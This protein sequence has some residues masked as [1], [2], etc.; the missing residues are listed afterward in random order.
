[1][2][3]E[4]VMTYIIGFLCGSIV[5]TIIIYIHEKIRD[6]KVED[7]YPSL[8][9]IYIEYKNGETTTINGVISGDVSG[10]W[11]VVETMTD[12]FAFRL[13]DVHRIRN[14]EVVDED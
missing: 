11:L 14:E 13:D 2:T 5:T 12:T 1:M 8:S 9:N 4:L 7:F 6:R 10:D 3:F